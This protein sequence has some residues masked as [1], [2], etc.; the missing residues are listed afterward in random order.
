MLKVLGGEQEGEFKAVASGTLP[1]GKP[2]VVNSD[3]TVS[4]I[5][6]TS[7]SIGSEVGIVTSAFQAAAAVYD[8]GQDKVL[9]IYNGTSQY[10]YAVVGTVSGSSISFGTP[11]VFI[12]SNIAYLSAV[13]DPDVG[14]TAIFF[15][16]YGQSEYG[17]CCVA[18][19][20]GTSVS[21]GSVTT[22]SSTTTSGAK[23]CTY[24]TTQ[25]KILLA[26]QETSSQSK[27]VAVT[28]SGTSLSFGTKYAIQG[29]N[30]NISD[31]AIEYDANADKSLLVYRN[32][33]NSNAID[34]KVVT[35]SGTT[36]SFGSLTSVYGSIGD[37]VHAAYDSTAQKVV[38][39]YRQD[40]G[41]P[42]MEMIVATISGTSVSYGTAASTGVNFGS[43]AE[44]DHHMNFNVA[45]NKIVLAGRDDSNSYVQ[46]YVTASVSGTSISIDTP[47]TYYSST[48]YVG[49]S[50]YDPDQEKSV[51]FYARSSFSNPGAK[52]LTVGSTNL[53][54][55][56]Y[57]GISS[58]GPVADT[59]NATVDI[60]GTVN[61]DQTGLTAGQKYYVQ[62]DGTLGTTEG[63]PSVLAGTAISSTELLVKT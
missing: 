36:V 62:S 45:A 27:V 5:A 10:G 17:K 22:F 41:S 55:E 56:N 19:I 29:S 63:S 34:S 20:S 51:L 28:M 60:V 2:V 26:F 42:V 24:D 59:G 40:T 58:G 25:N 14:N 12:S 54:A 43:G 32:P 39:A 21:F 61:K 30:N 11:S 47:V 46:K 3:G 31:M 16:D 33:G 23:D 48:S 1:N 50:T 15:A 38:V 44:Q 7:D 52:V 37:K 9:F 57:I 4:V 13:Y 35:L 6:E 18:T 8:T 53:T 49:A